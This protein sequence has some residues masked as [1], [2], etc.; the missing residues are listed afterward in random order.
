LTLSS[1]TGFARTEGQ[2]DICSWSWELKS[3][4]A[5]GLDIRCRLPNS[6]DGLEPIV[7]ERAAKIFRRGN[8]SIN[9]MSSKNQSASAFQI[10]R[11]ALEDIVKLIPDVE[12][13]FG[14]LRPPSIAELLNLR[15]V[16]E[17]VEDSISEDA[18]KALDEAVLEDL[19]QTLSQLAV[20][21]DQE[22]S[23]LGAVLAEQLGTI[24]NLKGEADNLAALQP[25]ALR[26]RM[27]AQL[28]EVLETVPALTEERLAQ[29]VAVLITKSDIREELDRLAA[30]V[31]AAGELMSS[32]AA[33]G[34]KLDFLCQE[35]NR[36][37]NTLCSKSSDV[38]LTRVGL[39][40]KAVI[41]Q[42]REQVQNIE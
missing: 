33:V 20:M 4:N 30:H 25:E 41:E 9:L 32:D 12:A 15:G 21:R 24:G 19:D 36:E 28:A 26:S 8:L 31:E 6:F 35:L 29:E 14:Q 37:A 42:F 16:M 34:R 17:P 7:R 2:N 18:K 40:L 3:V 10:N 11:Q 39:N 22:G 5:K 23:R 13:G 27:Q 1:M 38:E